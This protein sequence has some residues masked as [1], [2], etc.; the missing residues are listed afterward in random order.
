MLDAWDNEFSITEKTL[1]H[2]RDQSYEKRQ[3]RTLAGRRRI[4][5][6][7]S[8][9]K[10][11]QF[12]LEKYKDKCDQ[13]KITQ[14]MQSMIAAVKREGGNVHYQ[15]SAADQ[16]LTAMGCGFDPNGKPYLW[17]IL[18]PEYNSMLLLYLYDEFLVE[19][20]EEHSKAVE[21]EVEDA[22]IRSGA[23]FVK[24]VPM[25]SEGMISKRWQK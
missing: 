10:A 19:S 24:S 7:V 20:P 23:E 14:T 12:A 15:G 22:I 21:A 11:K 9:E 8:Y 17:H 5:T 18:E 2:L 6:P 3:A 1:V 4:I 25:A 16:M 13:N